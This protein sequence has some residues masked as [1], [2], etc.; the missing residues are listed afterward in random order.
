MAKAGFFSCCFLMR[1]RVALHIC[2]L[3]ATKGLSCLPKLSG[4]PVK[5][6]T[7][8]VKLQCG[9]ESIRGSKVKLRHTETMN[10]RLLANMPLAWHWIMTHLSDQAYQSI[11]ATRLGF[12]IQSCQMH[13][14]CFSRTSAA[15][16]AV[17]VSCRGS[18][19]FQLNWMQDIIRND[20]KLE[21]VEACQ[22]PRNTRI[23]Q[24]ELKQS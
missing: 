9:F 4:A 13:L 19:L 5:W 17:L 23:I 11:R 16:P 6:P 8:V 15:W 24:L 21:Q 3:K 18:L 20:I 22:L 7:L 14:S 2:S 10:P 12:V 1:F